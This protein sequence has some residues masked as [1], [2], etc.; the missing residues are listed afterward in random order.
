MNDREDG[1]EGEESAGQRVQGSLHGLELINAL[2][3]VA[4]P[5]LTEG[6][7][8]VSAQTHVLSVDHIIGRLLGF[9]PSVCQL[10]GESLWRRG[11]RQQW[12]SKRQRLKAGQRGSL[13]IVLKIQYPCGQATGEP[14]CLQFWPTCSS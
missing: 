4:L 13:L 11:N 14:K 6:L 8:L 7:V 3:G 9:I 5:N 1:T 10:R 12:V 2:L